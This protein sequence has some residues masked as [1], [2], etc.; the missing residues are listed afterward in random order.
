MNKN[1]FIELYKNYDKRELTVYSRILEDKYRELYLCKK[2]SKLLT[3]PHLTLISIYDNYHIFKN[4][5]DKETFNINFK[6]VTKNQLRDISWDNILICGR[7][8]ALSLI[9]RVDQNSEIDLYIY[10]LDEKEANKKLLYIYNYLDSVYSELNCYKYKD[11]IK[12]K[13]DLFIVN[14]KLVLYKSPAEILM[15]YNIDC[16]SVCY[17]GEKVWSTPRAHFALTN[18]VNYV[19][20]FDYDSLE[21]CHHLGFS[22]KFYNLKHNLLNRNCK[23]ISNSTNVKS[24]TMEQIINGYPFIN[25]KLRWNKNSYKR[26]YEEQLDHRIDIDKINLNDIEKLIDLKDYNG[27]TVI[28]CAIIYNRLNIF[29]K[30]INTVPI[31]KIS[32]ILCLICEYGRV[33]MLREIDSKYMKY[34]RKKY[35]DYTPLEL[36]VIFNR[37]CIVDYVLEKIELNCNSLLKLSCLLDRKNIAKKIVARCDKSYEIVKL[38]SFKYIDLLNRSGIDEILWAIDNCNYGLF[39]KVININKDTIN[40][41][42]EKNNMCNMSHFTLLDYISYKI[43]FYK[44]VLECDNSTSFLNSEIYYYY[45]LDRED[46]EDR[47]IELL[48]MEQLVKNSGGKK[49]IDM[50]HSYQVKSSAQKMIGPMVTIFSKRGRK[51]NSK[52]LHHFESLWNGENIKIDH[53]CYSNITKRTPL[54]IVLER[55]HINIF[56]LWIDKFNSSIDTVIDHLI[57]LNITDMNIIEKLDISNSTPFWKY[58]VWCLKKGYIELAEYFVKNKI[59]SAK[60]DDYSTVL[61]DICRAGQVKSLL[62]LLK[63]AKDIIKYKIFDYR[64]TDCDENGNSLLHYVCMDKVPKNRTEDYLDCIRLLYKIYPLII[65]RCNSLKDTPL[66]VSYRTENYLVVEKLLEFGAEVDLYDCSGHN[67]FQST[68]RYLEKEDIT[69]KILEI[70]LMNSY[71]MLNKKTKNTKMTPLHIALKYDKKKVANY[72]LEIGIEIDQIDIFGNYESNYDMYDIMDCKN[73]ENNFGKTKIDCVRD[74]IKKSIKSKNRDNLL[75]LL[76]FHD[77]YREID[78]KMFN[79]SSIIEMCEKIFEI[80]CDG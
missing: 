24:L 36:A 41:I 49:I 51:L 9:D 60:I 80:N 14:I 17:D 40:L 3:D 57:E 6:L 26:R 74:Q 43:D 29:Q 70:V 16:Y 25:S 67:I 61:F 46:I 66:M 64:V 10:N 38:F 21:E 79:S 42:I 18:R 62:F 50:E 37:E 76:E 44:K 7:C 23:D 5:V 68:I 27:R 22:L 77:K 52:Y 39:E 35:K 53:L 59:Y 63:W 33:G 73:I 2:D 20:K 65:N 13:S 32:S 45:M 55:K 28:E 12:I 1:N 15:D 69:V 4:I 31:S 58:Y 75:E 19:G 11:H 30:L 54:Y 34:I 71:S 72:L 78:R 8:V 47:T 48:K 56:N